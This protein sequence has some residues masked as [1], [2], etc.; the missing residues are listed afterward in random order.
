MCSRDKTHEFYIKTFVS[1]GEQT[2]TK[3]LELFVDY[4]DGLPVFARELGDSA[5]RMTKTLK[6][7]KDAVIDGILDVTEIIGRKLL[8]Q[9]V[10]NAIRSEKY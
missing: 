9:Q 7:D 3:D 2:S 8:D 1:A 10:F 6:I 4:T 5:W